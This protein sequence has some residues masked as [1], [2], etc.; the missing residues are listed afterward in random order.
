M[1]K[2]IEN[3]ARWPQKHI[4]QIFFKFLDKLS[5]KKKYNSVICANFDITA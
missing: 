2:T 4:E 3:L 1:L 5:P